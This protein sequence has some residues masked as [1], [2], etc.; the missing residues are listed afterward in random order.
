MAET[1]YSIKLSTLTEIGDAI[2]AKSGATGDIAVTSL[3]TSILDLS[4]ADDV[5]EWDGS[6]VVIAPIES[7]Q[8]MTFT[9]NGTSYQMDNQMTWYAWTRSDYNTDGFSCA[10]E[11]DY[12]Y[13]A[14]SSNKVTDAD[15]NDVLGTTYI[16]EGGAYLIKEATTTDELAGTW[17]FNNTVNIPED[18]LD[19]TLNFQCNGVQYT[20]LSVHN[21]RFGMP[22]IVA[23]LYDGS[24]VYEPSTGWYEQYYRTIF[25][26]SKLSEVTNGS[27]LLTWLKA[28]AVKQTTESESVVGVWY[29]NNFLS[30]GPFDY[31]LD[32]V[33]NGGSYVRIYADGDL[34]TGNTLSYY[35]QN[36]SRVRVYYEDQ[37]NVSSSY[38]TLTIN[39]EPS[40]TAVIE[41]L[42]VNA[43]KQDDVN[44]GATND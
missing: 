29:L 22:P 17:V 41:W 9:I 11:N 6:G 27:A 28:N 2:R 30:G 20:L 3:A 1:Y 39:S 4:P 36:N 8:P 5:I 7:E 14:E 25:I 18:V 12:V 43:T 16:V 24:N 37:Y 13:E 44:E 26:T 38:R 33:S 35:D 32:F 10:E 21:I 23:V 15:G 34:A 40:D 31:D 19:W 42:K